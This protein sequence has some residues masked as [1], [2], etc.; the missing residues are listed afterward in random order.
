MGV[1]GSKV[2]TGQTQRSFAAADGQIGQFNHGCYLQFSKNR[3]KRK[4]VF[5]IRQKRFRR[6]HEKRFF[7]LYPDRQKKAR[8]NS[9]TPCQILPSELV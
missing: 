2:A 8:R 4:G 5:H 6:T 1:I 7:S 3:E 9:R